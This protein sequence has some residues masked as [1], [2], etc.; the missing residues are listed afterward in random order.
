M[1]NNFGE[2]ATNPRDLNLN[3]DIAY[4]TIQN[5]LKNFVFVNI[6]EDMDQSLS[7]FKILTG[8]DKID[9]GQENLP[10]FKNRLVDGKSTNKMGRRRKRSSHTHSTVD[11]RAK[12][13]SKELISQLVEKN[14]Q[15]MIVWMYFR[16]KLEI[17]L[18]HYKNSGQN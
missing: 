5:I 7:L 12:L 15:D 14:R 3:D 1:T 2:N 10:V 13:Y 8:V 11:I 6:F 18:T 16:K 4:K 9:D 17:S